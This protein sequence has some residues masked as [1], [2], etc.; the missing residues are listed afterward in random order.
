MKRITVKAI[1]KKLTFFSSAAVAP[2]V[3]ST[4]MGAAVVSS[5]PVKAK[6]ET[7]TFL[8]QQINAMPQL[9]CKACYIKKNKK[10]LT[11]W[12]RCTI[13]LISCNL[14]FHG[15]SLSADCL[16]SDATFYFG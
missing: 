14:A 12:N 5:T 6:E 11:Q 16:P 4:S 15:H 10:T 7:Y 2:S 8:S 13:Y 9:C 1:V 3:A